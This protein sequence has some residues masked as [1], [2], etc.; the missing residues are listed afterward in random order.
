[1]DEDKLRKID[2]QRRLL[3]DENRDIIREIAVA[4][5]LYH[6]LLERCNKIGKRIK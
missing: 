4:N 2:E 3:K 6:E 1:M 5:S